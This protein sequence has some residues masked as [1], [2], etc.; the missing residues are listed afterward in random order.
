MYIHGQYINQKGETIS[1]YIVT[2]QS[3]TEE[4]EIEGDDGRLLWTDDSVEI[5][6]EIN[7]TFDVI[8]AQS[9]TIRLQARE[10]I[11]DFFCADA[12]DAVVNVY[13][14]DQCVFAGFIEPQSYSQPYNEVYDEVELNCIDALSAL[15]YSNYRDIGSTLMTYAIA[16]AEANQRTFYEIIKEMLDSVTENLDILGNGTIKYLYDHSR[17]VNNTSS[18]YKVQ[19]FQKI[20]IN[21]LLFLGD[22]E[23]DVWTA[24]DVMDA[25]LMFFNLHIVQDGL[26]FRIF[27]WESVKGSDTI[28]WEDIETGE[29]YERTENR[30]TTD[31][32][33]NIVADCDTQIS[34]GEIYN[35][36][37]LTATIEKIDSVV[38]SPLDDD[39]IDSPYN[40]GTGKQ[41]YCT[42]ISTAGEGKTSIDAF[43]Q[44]THDGNTTY[45]G[46]DITEWYVRVMRSALW[47]FYA[48]GEVDL[49]EK[50]NCDLGMYQNKLPDF[51]S[52]N[53]GCALLAFGKIEKNA[54]QDDNSKTSTVDMTNYLVISVNG[55]EVDNDEDKT[56]PSISD[57]KGMIPCAEYTGNSA[58]GNFSPT[59]NNTKNY[60]VISGKL[61]L[62]PIV[63]MTD[64]YKAL[65]DSTDWTRSKLVGITYWH[66]TVDDPDSGNRYYTRQ[67]WSSVSPAQEVGWNPLTSGG[68]IPP[69]TGKGLQKYEY[70]YNEDGTKTDQ[71]SKV[72]VLACMLIIGDKCVVESGT[73]GQTD[74]FTWQPYKTLEECADEDEYYQ[75]C[76]YIGF[77][78]KIGDKLIGT[79]FDIQ[80]NIDYTM[81]LD[82][83]GMAI[84]ITKGDKVS[85]RV[86][87]KILGPVNTTWEQTTRRHPTFFR[88]TSWS[89]ESVSLL[90]HVSSIFIKDFK[91]EVMS[92][93]GKISLV[94]TDND[95][96]YMSDTVETFRNK[97][98]DLE[99]KIHS[100]LTSAECEALGVANDVKLSTPT[101]TTSGDAVLTIHD[102]ISGETAKAEQLYVNAYYQ[103]WHAPRI[104][105]DQNVEDGSHV[106]LF[107]HYRHPALGKT[108]FVEGFG[109][110]LTEGTV[111]LKLKE[112]EDND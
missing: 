55:N 8:V 56:Y 12:R 29:I 19:V 22:E 67:Y 63:K 70:A 73:D 35:Q 48:S 92:D 106:G 109:R 108:F 60:I 57:I 28:Y 21:D 34:V 102:N 76:F 85:G 52:E 44:L 50:F 72:A 82:T 66:H 96:V 17:S 49:L 32:A 23:D 9:A 53:L 42:E 59:D 78:P 18:L 3:R 80:N 40:E 69:L 101:D 39:N 13:K 83:D 107:N 62:N 99:M 71:V 41:K 33:T 45:D 27:A 7:D 47:N 95:V 111:Q 94:N 15:Q 14:D 10:H 2:K 93:N 100:A 16:K 11:A 54:A 74:K 97:K 112:I 68:L 98:D 86:T 37:E 90:A 104:E 36:L 5:A 58:G 89:T 77:D 43:Y 105:M 20:T 51:L 25:M 75:Q 30:T 46:A 87:F 64:T 79:E 31:I 84:P 65:H 81:G 1:V 91:V 103:E 24:E 88:H 38:E 61:L 110:N 6:T 26:L 4:I